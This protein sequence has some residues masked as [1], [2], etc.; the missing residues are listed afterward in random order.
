MANITLRRNPELKG[1]T[2]LELMVTLGILAIVLTIALANFK[3]IAV[4]G[5]LRSAARDIV[6][7][8][9]ALKQRAVSED[10]MYKIQLDTGGGTYSLQQ[11]NNQGSPCGGFSQ[12]QSKNLASIAPDISFD[13]G[14][15]SATVY[16]FQ[17]RGTVNSG[18]IA[19]LNSLNSQASIKINF[20]G[21]TSVKFTML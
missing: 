6:S 20:T 14:E 10:R 13:P 18:T 17:T 11:C 4:N 8:F 19:L 12:I 16:T 1:F 5:N 15:T 2:I 9:N 21:R 7:D 3:R